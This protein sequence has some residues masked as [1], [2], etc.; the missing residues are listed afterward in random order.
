MLYIYGKSF[1]RCGE[2]IIRKQVEEFIVTQYLEHCIGLLKDDNE[3]GVY[4]FLEN[5]DK[6]Q[7]GDYDKG[8]AIVSI[9]DNNNFGDDES[10]LVNLQDRLVCIKND[11]PFSI[12]LEEHAFGMAS[13][14]EKAKLA[15]LTTEVEDD[16]EDED[17]G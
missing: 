17:W 3:E 2:T 8:T 9:L 4:N 6:E 10:H 12:D 16:E 1:D 5:V 13:T 11:V 7:S 15:Y 14:K